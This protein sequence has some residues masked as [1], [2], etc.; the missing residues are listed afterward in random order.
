MNRNTSVFDPALY[1]NVRKPLRQ[2]ET[3]PHWCYTSLEFHQRE[4]ERI[5]EPGWTF[6][7][8]IDEIATPGQYMTSQT[9]F[10]SVCVIRDESNTVH[11][12]INACRHRG[13]QL[14]DGTGECQKI[15]CPYHSWVYALNGKLERARGMEDIENFALEDHGLVPLRFEVW[16]GFMFVTSET[17][18]PSLMDY[19]GDMPQRFA[20][21]KPSE[22]ITTRRIE[23]DVRCN[24]KLLIENALEAYHTGT[25]HRSTLGQQQWESVNTQGNWD[26][27]MVLDEKSVATLPGQTTVLPEI[28]GL[29]GYAKRGTI[30]TCIYPCTQF[31]F[32]PDC[33][34]WLHIQPTGVGSCHLTLGSCFP[35]DT[36]KHPQFDEL[37]KHYYHRWDTA[38][39][40]DNRISESQ[41]IG[42]S[43]AGR[44]PGRFATSEFAVHN[45]ANWMLDRVLGDK[46]LNV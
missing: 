32:A 1:Q 20:Q 45:L 37:I 39:P 35:K 12:F 24:W 33:M 5:F 31:V 21:Y 16:D 40:E 3:L 36:L 11:A 18:G 2:A 6:V 46:N 19:L 30:F 14:L 13:T 15:V 29:S 9:V 10:G 38:T 27:L 43:A 7:G 22:L 28:E 25:V 23:F 17:Q 34:W 44:K 42:Q 26:A 8:R 41:Q 4:I